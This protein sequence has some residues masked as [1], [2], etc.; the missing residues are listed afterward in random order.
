MDVLS[1]KDQ[2]YAPTGSEYYHEGNGLI[3]R[4]HT[5]ES[6]SQRHVATI[7]APY[8]PP[9]DTVTRRETN[10]DSRFI[11]VLRKVFLTCPHK[12]ALIPC[13]TPRTMIR[14]PVSIYLSLLVNA[15]VL[16]IITVGID[17]ALCGGKYSKESDSNS[18]R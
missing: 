17:E 4:V 14:Q 15:L 8:F 9:V 13:A 10:E 11:Y 1:E 12:S 18:V 7:D 6:W 16:M 5:R 3:P 2:Q